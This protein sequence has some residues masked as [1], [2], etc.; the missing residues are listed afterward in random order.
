MSCDEQ[1]FSHQLSNG[2]GRGAVCSV[3]KVSDVE[4][5]RFQSFHVFGK[6]TVPALAVRRWILNR[7]VDATRSDGQSNLQLVRAAGGQQEEN[8]RV[9]GDAIYFAEKLVPLTGSIL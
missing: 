4:S 5:F 3:H 2:G 7:L 9:I 1:R 8:A 6:E